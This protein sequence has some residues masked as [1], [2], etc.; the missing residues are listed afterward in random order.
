MLV[1]L[2]AGSVSGAAAPATSR[3]RISDDAQSSIDAL[4]ED[5]WEGKASFK[6]IKRLQI[7]TNGPVA[8]IVS[9]PTLMDSGTQ[10]FAM[11]NVD[12]ASQLWYLFNREYFYD[13]V[14]PANCPNGV[15]PSR[16]VVRSSEDRG[17]TW[18]NE[19]VI[20]QPNVAAGEC[21]VA[22]GHAFFDAETNTWHY[23]A[24]VYFG[25]ASSAAPPN[26]WHL[27]H[28]TLG[29]RNPMA[30][31]APDPANPVVKSAQLWDAICGDGNACPA[32]TRE[33]G[34]PEISFK[35]NGDYYVT[36]HGAY[37]VNP[38]WGYRGI[39]K[40]SDFHGWRTH[41]DDAADPYLPAGPLWSQR[42]CASWNVSW[43]RTTGCIGG[44][45]AGSLVTPAYTYMLI[46]SAD[47]SLSCTPEQNWVIGLVRAPKFSG[48]GKPQRFVASGHW[49][50]YA[51]NPLI[52]SHNHH[53]CSIQYPRF[54]VD[55]SRVYLTYWTI[56]TKGS[57]PSGA[58]DDRASFLR[59]AQ[60]VS[61]A[62]FTRR[63]RIL[64]RIPRHGGPGQF[65]LDHFRDDVL[66]VSL[67]SPSQS[68]LGF[69]GVA[70]AV[71]YIS[72]SE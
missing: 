15:S 10:I 41:A 35:T 70:F 64:A 47:L 30:H 4:L 39:A 71:R 50:Q 61:N 6:E 11:S 49:Q 52:D 66:H 34:T 59:I 62:Q 68:M 13:A 23:I 1:A 51:K 32:G 40:T 46:E 25:L 45:H 60:L 31:F 55:G 44:G 2:L 67:G 36:F 19:V 26:T 20:A 3:V 18:S 29:G 72:R 21:E 5:L 38:T 9:H 53:P 69:G 14:Q 22:D 12:S 24:Q 56:E 65:S 7:Q 33:E 43:S 17:D 48:S 57:A 28:Y 54:F 8:P 16:I 42:D 63:A 37:G 27:D 58:L